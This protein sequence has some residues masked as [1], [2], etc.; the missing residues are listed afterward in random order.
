MKQYQAQQVIICLLHTCIVNQLTSLINHLL[1]CKQPT[2]EQK[3]M[4]L[5]L[6]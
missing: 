1:V 6:H 5:K 2:K 4:Q 3:F